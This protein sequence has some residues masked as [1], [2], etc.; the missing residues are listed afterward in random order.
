MKRAICHHVNCRK[1]MNK[2]SMNIWNL[3]DRA[4]L[5]RWSDFLEQSLLGPYFF[6]DGK[7]VECKNHEMG[8]KSR[9]NVCWNLEG[10]YIKETHGSPYDSKCMVKSWDM[11]V[12]K[13]LWY[14]QIIHF[15]RV[16]HYKPSILWY[17]SVWKHPYISPWKKIVNIFCC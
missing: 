8:G 6:W 7:K 12:S 14:P 1:V 11:G 15:N 17:T 5:F 10:W 2:S 4:F 9:N 16:F 3:L 13:K